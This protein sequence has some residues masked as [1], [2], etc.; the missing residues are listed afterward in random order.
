MAIPTNITRDHILWVIN[1]IDDTRL[2]VPPIRQCRS[3]AL[4][5]NNKRYPVKYLISWANTIPNRKEFSYNEFISDEAIRYL[6]NLKFDI[7]DI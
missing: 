6:L 2:Q 5:Y 3:K 4:L 7:I 1:Q